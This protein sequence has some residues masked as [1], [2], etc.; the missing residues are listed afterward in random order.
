V[1]IQQ[2]EIERAWPFLGFMAAPGKKSANVKFCLCGRR[3]DH[4]FEDHRWRGSP[5]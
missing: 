2:L 1:W 5:N 4:P 3:Q